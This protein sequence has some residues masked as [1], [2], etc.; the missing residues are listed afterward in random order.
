MTRVFSLVLVALLFAA[1]SAAA[2]GRFVI[3]LRLPSGQTV[4]VSEGEFEARSIGSFSIRLYQSAAPENGTTFF[5]SGLVSA[6]EGVVEK[7]M[8]ADIN[9]D[10]LAEIIVIVRSVGTGSYLSAHAFSVDMDQRLFL[11]AS[12]EGLQS[13]ADPVSALRE[14]ILPL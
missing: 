3:K 11:L 6:R 4:V 14:T 5:I 13:T 10:E 12:I 9:G 1:S 2:A 7:V 8:L